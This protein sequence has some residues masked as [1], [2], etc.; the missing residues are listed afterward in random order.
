[1]NL[2]KNIAILLG[3]VLLS[4]ILAIYYTRLHNIDLAYNIK[5]RKGSCELMIELGMRDV[6]CVQ[7][8][9]EN[10]IGECISYRDLYIM[11]FG[12]LLFYIPIG[13]VLIALLIGFGL[14]KIKK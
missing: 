14:G 9:E 13:L 3:I 6:E 5:N 7:Y 1:M 8:C 4:Y 11:S 10:R 2:R 12:Q